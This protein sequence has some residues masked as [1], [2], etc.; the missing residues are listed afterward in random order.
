MAEEQSV[1]PPPMTTTTTTSAAA[2]ADQTNQIEMNSNTFQNQDHQSQLNQIHQNHENHKRPRLDQPSISPQQSSQPH[3]QLQAYHQQQPLQ[4][5]D[6][7]QHLLP[8]PTQTEHSSRD[9]TPFSSSIPTETQPIQ[10]PLTSF[11]SASTQQLPSITS[12]APDST[13]P[14]FDPNSQQSA[15][16]QQPPQPPTIE[17]SRQNPPSLTSPSPKKKPEEIAKQYLLSQTQP[18][19]IP[20]YASWF[21]LDTIHPLEQKALP[22]F[23][24]GRNRSK[25]P[26]IY[27]DYRDFIV[28]SYRLNPSEYLTLTS[29]RRNLAGDVCAIMR[30]H[31]FLEQWGI[32]NYQVDA[33]TRPAPVGPPFTGHFRVLLDT[34]RGLMPLHSGVVTKHNKNPPNLLTPDV[35]NPSQS[36]ETTQSFYNHA[37]QIRKNIYERTETGHEV[38]V[39]E[40]KAQNMLESNGTTN[41]EPT[42]ERS[43]IQC[44]VCS[45]ECTKLSYHHTKLRTYDLCPGCYSQG[46]FPSTMNAAEFIRMD[47]DLSNAPIPAEWSNQE[48]LLLL[49]GLE[50]FADDWEKIVDHV[51]GTKTKQQCILEF[52]RLPIEDEFLKSVEKDVGG[53]M[54]LGKMPLNGVD[55]PVMSVLTFLMGLVEPD[56]TARLAGTSIENIKED[57]ESK[58]VTDSE[59]LA[60]KEVEEEKKKRKAPGD[61]RVIPSG[62]SRAEDTTTHQD[63]EDNTAMEVDEPTTQIQPIQSTS[64]K[65]QKPIEKI[66]GIALGSA[67]IKASTLS[68]EADLE[69][70]KLLGNLTEQ[71]VNKLELKLQ[72]FEKLESLVE[73]ERRNLEQFR[74]SLLIE[75]MMLVKEIG[76][77]RDLESG[78]VKAKEVEGSNVTNS[79]MNGGV[80]VMEIA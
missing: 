40:A 25:V 65:A 49:E 50:M 43:P 34:P 79:M 53:P 41:N 46:R 68:S 18:I 4:Q 39:D 52:L 75:R 35:P 45:V 78:G 15:P 20:S 69:M 30:V 58:V 32:I 12:N 48:R 71:T 11:S 21:D 14:S 72:Q 5:L 60:R 19:I 3:Q 59:K 55:N 13:I 26:S 64:P 8:N 24:N 17:I 37:L 10:Q 23:F 51:G 22:E 33:D 9:H 63:E 1:P 62:G 7:S 73:I 80:G 56:V 29:C 28:N 70:N 6:Q 42:A 36:S 2:A 54:G 47:R 76:K 74:Q 57:I 16:A 38:E 66:V 27:K 77:A 61:D 44:D 67:A 31:A